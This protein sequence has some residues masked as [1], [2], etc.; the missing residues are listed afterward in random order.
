MF[1]SKQ[2]VKTDSKTSAPG[3]NL[4]EKQFDLSQCAILALT[5]FNQIFN[6]LFTLASDC[7]LIANHFFDPVLAGGYYFAKLE[8]E[9]LSN[10]KIMPT[11]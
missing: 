3:I 2:T 10:L 9:I 5:S 7:R 8:R 11:S 6:S 1:W 4:P